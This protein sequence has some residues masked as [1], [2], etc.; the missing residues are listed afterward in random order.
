MSSLTQETA[1]SVACSPTKGYVIVIGNFDFNST[2]DSLIA[3]KTRLGFVGESLTLGDS[4]RCVKQ[5]YCTRRRLWHFLELR[6]V[7]ENISL[8]GIFEVGF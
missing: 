7:R 3:T 2:M 8:D 5:L 1:I 6:W 4:D